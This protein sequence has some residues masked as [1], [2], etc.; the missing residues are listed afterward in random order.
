MSSK[1]DT[2]TVYWSPAKFIAD[3]DSWSLLYP[4]PKPVLK[5]AYKLNKHK[6]IMPLCP[7]VKDTLGNVYSFNS[8]LSDSFDL[9]TQVMESI[10]YTDTVEEP[11]PTESKLSFYKMRKSSM[12]GYININY[13]MAWLFF[14]SEPVEAKMTAPYFPATSPVKGALFSAGQFNIGK[15][16]RPVMMDYHIPTTSNK[17]EIEAGDPLF[18]IDLITDKK[19]EFKRFNLSARLHNLATEMGSSTTRYEKRQSLWQRYQMAHNAK[20]PQMILTE[21]R[22]NLLDD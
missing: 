3:T 18:F 21:I 7:A 1:K 15:W 5:E 2:I 22:K 17:F 6:G 9:P 13:N 10:A 12:D 4:E 8:A 16:F 19:I 14:A 11:I 20:I